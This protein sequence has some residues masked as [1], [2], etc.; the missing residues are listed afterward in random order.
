MIDFEKASV[1]KLKEGNAAELGQSVAAILLDDELVI[2]A[3]KG[4]RDYVV[5]TDK[6][7][8]TV[9]VQGMT[10]KKQ[11]F[12][13]L[14][15]SKVQAWSRVTPRAFGARSIGSIAWAMTVTSPVWPARGTS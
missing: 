11:D 6:R 8:I 12:T 13:S 5:L 4:A 3:Y 1:F 2:A 9:N 7:L 14:P 10:G 15:W